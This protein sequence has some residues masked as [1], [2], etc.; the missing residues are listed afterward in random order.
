MQ[1][2]RGNSIRGMRAD[3]RVLM[4]VSRQFAGDAQMGFVA[5]LGNF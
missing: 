3:V 1:I 2:P 5:L 4:H